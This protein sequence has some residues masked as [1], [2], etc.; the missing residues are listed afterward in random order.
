MK[1]HR[2]AAFGC[3]YPLRSLT[4]KGDLLAAETRLVADHGARA[5][6]AL[7]AVAHRDARRFAFNSKDKLSA[8]AGGASGDH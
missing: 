3:P 4:G 8:T 7:E 1:G 5:A 6:L 2:V